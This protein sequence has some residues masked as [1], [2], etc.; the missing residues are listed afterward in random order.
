MHSDLFHFMVITISSNNAD[1]ND[2]WHHAIFIFTRSLI[3]Y[4]YYNNNVIDPL[5]KW[6]IIITIQLS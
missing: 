5:P 1:V 3:F 2:L 6:L 4:R